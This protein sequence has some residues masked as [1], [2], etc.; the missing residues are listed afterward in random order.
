MDGTAVVMTDGHLAD[1][2]GKTAHGL[3]RGSE[4]FKVMAVIDARHAGRDA[5]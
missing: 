1:I 3:I 2:Y 5:G 4:R